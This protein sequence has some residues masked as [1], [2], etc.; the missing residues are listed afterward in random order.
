MTPPLQLISPN[1]RIAATIALDASGVPNYRVSFDRRPLIA[2]SPLGLRLASGD[3]PGRGTGFG[4]VAGSSGEQQYTLIAGKKR[5]ARDDYRQIEADVGRLRLIVRVSDE[6]VAFRY[7]IES[8][9]NS[10]FVADELT[11]FNFAH[12]CT[13]WGLDLGSFTTGHEGEFRRMRAS[14]IGAGMLLDMPLV[15]EAEGAAFAIAEADLNDY[16][17]LY[18]CGHGEGAGVQ[19]RLSPLP[20][21][22][23]IAVRYRPGAHLLS[24]WRVV[25]IAERPGDLIR[26]TLITS[27]NPPCPTADTGW[28]RP[29][30]YA[31]DW[32][33]GGVVSGA[34]PAGM[35]DTVI[36][37]F[38]DFAAVARLRYMLI[39]AGWYVAPDGDVGSPAADVTRSIPD[40]HL[41]ELVAYG[42]RRNVGLLVWAH[43]RPLA[44]R[45]DAA[46]AWYQRLGLEGIKVDFMDRNDQVMVNFIHTLLGKAS[47]HRLIVDLHGVCPPT[48]LSRTY[49]NLLTQ[50]GVMGAEY[51]KWSAGVTATHNVTLPFTRMLLGPMDYTPG[52]FRNVTPADFVPRGVLPLVQTTRAHG[53]A[54][55]V[56]YDSPLVSLADTPDAYRHQ[57]GLDF[58]STVPTT[59]HE[60][61]VLAGEIG[62][63][64]VIARRN[65]PDWFVGAMTNEAARTLSVTLDLLGDGPFIARTYADC[66]APTAVDITETTVRRG[67]TIGLRLAPS[68]GAGVHVR[69]VR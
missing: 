4:R 21:E 8:D 61:R 49:P 42:R 34:A 11:R 57:P 55:Y 14:G 51:N 30:K 2:P 16:A 50:E 9:G 33:S 53:L 47:R 36:K 28:I 45:M 32:W 27:L 29:G 38:I 10:I 54:M 24:P 39:D 22:P 48:G 63:F 67:D 25:M 17:G 56:V 3:V 18:L 40:L 62:Q 60:T 35:T 69:P 6:G 66:D 37:R 26:S 1:G 20:D 12:D 43:W 19:A 15:C 64:V 52:G 41:P 68:G 65:G 7:S 46:L 59:W 58:L 13:C 23:A 44:A 31:W 5:Q